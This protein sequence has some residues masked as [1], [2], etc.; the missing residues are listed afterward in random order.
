MGGFGSTRWDGV[1]TKRQ[2]DGSFRLSAPPAWMIAE[3]AGLWR[4]PK[5]GFSV[6]FDLETPRRAL[7]RYVTR[8]GLWSPR[9]GV[10]STSANLGGSRWWWLCPKCERRCGKLYLPPRSDVLACRLCHSLSYES[11]QSSRASYYDT[12]KVC[13]RR[14]GRPSPYLRS[15]G[16]PVLTATYFRERIREEG[17]GFR[18]ASYEGVSE[19]LN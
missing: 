9:V 8:A 16:V 4:W 6:R 11:A 19:S 13:A 7:L 14:Y 5:F 12:F 2:A 3:G 15:I 10:D 18:V 17:D 1:P